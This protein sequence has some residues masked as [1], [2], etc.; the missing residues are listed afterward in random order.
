M[1]TSYKQ[2]FL[3]YHKPQVLIWTYDWKSKLDRTY[4]IIT[5]MHHLEE[6]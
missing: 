6:K 3:T 2:L 1:W 4:I 5:H